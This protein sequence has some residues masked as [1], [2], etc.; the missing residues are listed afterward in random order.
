MLTYNILCF[1]IIALALTTGLRTCEISR[2]NVGN[3][4]DAG[5]YWTLDI[6]D[7]GHLQADATVKVAP[8]VAALINSY[9]ELRGAVGDDE[10]LFISTSRNVKWTANSYG[11]RLSEQ[12]V[13]KLIRRRMIEGGIAKPAERDAAT[14]K[15]KRSRSPISAHSTRH[16]A[17]TRAIKN[18]VDLR[19]VGDMLRH[20]DLN[21][22]LRYLHDISLETR[23]AELSVAESLFGA[24]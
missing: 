13:G 6:V 2:A 22:T 24:A 8:A 15:V 5:D 11:R 7:K 12:S 21:T 10:P 19:E 3:F 1:I 4:K 17:A 23:R 16:Y 20:V 9:L 14:G 18:G